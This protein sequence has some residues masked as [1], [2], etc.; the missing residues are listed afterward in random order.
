MHS[1][2]VRLKLSEFIDTEIEQYVI[3]RINE[4]YKIHQ[5]KLHFWYHEDELK[6][7]QLK[8]FLEKHEKELHFRTKITPNPDLKTGEFI[9]FDI[10]PESMV[11]QPNTRFTYIGD[12]IS[13]L[14]QLQ[15]A[16][17]FCKKPKNEKPIRKQKRND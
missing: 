3:D 15:E 16:V 5:F 8:T 14:N 12:V 1:I 4:V 9:W 11:E 10:T 13:G 6:P 17:A 7:K 2:T